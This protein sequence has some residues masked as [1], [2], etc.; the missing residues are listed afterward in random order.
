VGWDGP[1][2][3]EQDVRDAV[4][5]SLSLSEAL[6]KL[7]L[8]AAGSNFRTLKRLIERYDISTEHMDPNWVLRGNRPNRKIP[9]EQIM[10][11]GSTYGRDK[12]KRRLY[13]DGLKERRCELCGQ[14]EVWNG[15]RMSLILDHI[16]GDA[17]DNRLENL[18]IVCPNCNA[19]LDTHCG[20]QNR[21]DVAARACLHCGAEFVP[22]YA[23]H[24]YCSQ[25]CGT[26][27]TRSRDP[28][29]QSRKVPRPPYEQ[30]MADLA[31]TNFCAVGRKYG[32][33]DNAVRKWVRWYEAAYERRPER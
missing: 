4:A 30:L 2:Y 5:G 24:R 20:R 3:T 13:E 26:Q 7:R 9:L 12:L 1:R 18:R 27:W 11:E 19:T 21:L 29:P 16:N 14:N 32:V 8:R 33:S 10:V 22:R 25:L 31:A 6:R 28:K 23:T 15:N 17:T